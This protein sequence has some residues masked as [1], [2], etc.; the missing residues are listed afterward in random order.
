MKYIKQFTI[1][2]SVCFI[3]EVIHEIIP[4]PI[5]GSIYG[6]VLMFLALEFKIMPLDKVEEISD[7]FLEIMPLLFVP[8]TVGLLVAWP[9]I[10]K[11]W[12]PILILGIAG[13]T[14]NFFV[15]GHVTQ[16]FARI[17]KKKNTSE[18]F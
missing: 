10:K 13:T 14:L 17:L 8:S 9:V 12:L 3:G 11:Y 1:F 7:Y 16:F 5:P 15:S 2:V 6:L 18:N 4:L